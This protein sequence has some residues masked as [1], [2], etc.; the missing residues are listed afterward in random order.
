MH[1]SASATSVLNPRSG[2]RAYHH[3]WEFISDTH[4]FVI[5]SSSLLHIDLGVWLRRVFQMVSQPFGHWSPVWV[6]AELGCISGDCFA[7]YLSSCIVVH[8]RQAPHSVLQSLM[9]GYESYIVASAI[10]SSQ[11]RSV[12]GLD[13]GAG[14]Y[15]IRIMRT[16][17]GLSVN[18]ENTTDVF[19]KA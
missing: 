16:L 14:R 3:L 2:L 15:R 10:T 1:E 6:A 18:R 17:V 7:Q 5:V 19:W 4:N 11:R 12:S 9:L 8:S 13:G